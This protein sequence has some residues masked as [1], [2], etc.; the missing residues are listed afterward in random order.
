MQLL[1]HLSELFETHIRQFLT[2]M[3]VANLDEIRRRFA[4][5]LDNAAT[6][7]GMQL[8]PALRDFVIKRAVRAMQNDDAGHM[9]TRQ[10][11]DQ[12]PENAPEWLVN[13]IAN[14][15]Q[16]FHIEFKDGFDA[17]LSH[18][19]DWIAADRNAER[20]IRATPEADFLGRLAEKADQYF[21]QQAAQHTPI[22]SENGEIVEM[23]FRTTPGTEQ[24]IAYKEKSLAPDKARGDVVA[25]WC[26][27]TTPEALDREG[28][29][30]GHC[31]GSYADLVRSQHVRIFSLRDAKNHPHVTLEISQ[32]YDTKSI[33]QVKG[34][35]N[36]PP[37]G[38]YAGYVRDFLN[39]L[40]IDPSDSGRGD[41]R[42]MGLLSH[43]GKFGT[44]ADIGGTILTTFQNGDTLR[45]LDEVGKGER[46]WRMGKALLTY[47][48]VE[49]TGTVPL[50]LSMP[51][52]DE[53]RS[54]QILRP[55]VARYPVYAANLIQYLNENK[56]KGWT[57]DVLETL[58]VFYDKL[59]NV[60]GKRDDLTE[61][62]FRHNGIT[63]SRLT[64]TAYIAHGD[65][66]LAS[67]HLTSGKGRIYGLYK[68][69]IINDTPALRELPAVMAAFADKF[70][71]PDLYSMMNN[72]AKDT[73]RGFG[74][75]RRTKQG[76]RGVPE[77]KTILRTKHGSIRYEANRLYFYSESGTLLGSVYTAG[78]K[79]NAGIFDIRGNHLFLFGSEN[80]R[81]VFQLI[82]DLGQSDIPSQV[83]WFDHGDLY[84]QTADAGFFQKGKKLVPLSQVVFSKAIPG[85]YTVESEVGEQTNGQAV[86][87][88]KGEQTIFVV[89]M[90]EDDTVQRISMPRERVDREA[91]LVKYREQL[92]LALNVAKLRIKKSLMPANF[93]QE[94]NGRIYPQT[95]RQMLELY[96]TGRLDL[97][98]GFVFRKYDSHN[99]FGQIEAKDADS[100][101]GYGTTVVRVNWSDEDRQELSYR[102]VKD[103]YLRQSENATVTRAQIIRATAKFQHFFHAKIEPY[104]SEELVGGGTRRQ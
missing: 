54:C 45:T 41:L 15:E 96:S 68:L 23:T 91:S 3:N 67:A 49:R 40:G 98:N 51:D 103:S 55:E 20:V 2:E 29:L 59:K 1:P 28:K 22:E 13:A 97:G 17:R 75:T 84:R 18:V 100:K 21:A 93:L 101:H 52:V 90:D 87:V 43:K 30:M 64:D 58:D 78:S 16:V 86:R 74:L 25:F 14:G 60:W 83:D 72:D 8:P 82:S 19:I 32:R 69:K 56:V 10:R 36:Q 24:V 42:G 61:V 88:T 79:E 92:A 7:R 46:D 48:Y 6:H 27:L 57:A 34:K 62:M 77:E 11:V 31:V 71:D 47:W 9:V 4:Q 5:L 33:N 73:I 39:D 65:T 66:L 95:D 50:T 26:E 70:L 81:E 89:S 35:R 104:L 99:S 63:V 37:V 44:I 94:R 85:G 12:A 38:K 102:M 80:R 76:Y 53:L